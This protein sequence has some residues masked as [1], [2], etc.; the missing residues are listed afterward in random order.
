MQV[1]FNK[2]KEDKDEEKEL[3]EIRIL[4]NDFSEDINNIAFNFIFADHDY[5]EINIH[6][7]SNTFK[8]LTQDAIDV[9]NF[10]NEENNN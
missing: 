6:I 2:E 3:S 4:N 8:G 1:V 9:F 7:A 10:I 5:D